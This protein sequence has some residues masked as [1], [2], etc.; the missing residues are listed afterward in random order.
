M[1]IKML[2]LLVLGMSVPAFGGPPDGA[3][4]SDAATAQVPSS[5]GACE[6]FLS[7]LHY[8]PYPLAEQLHN[9]GLENEQVQYLSGKCLV[10]GD[11][12][13]A[14]GPFLVRSGH[15]VLSADLAYTGFSTADLSYELR[16]HIDTYRKLMAGRMINDSVTNL[17]D[18]ASNSVG[19]V[20]AH[21]L[22]NNLPHGDRYRALHEMVRV[23]A[24][25]GEAYLVD[26]DDN[27][28]GENDL[29]FTLRRLEREGKIENV[30]VTSL[31]I[32]LRKDGPVRR[33]RYEFTKIK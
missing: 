26:Q 2:A 29:T 16:I 12:F 9:L 5:K 11:G 1:N 13:S 24:P 21:M 14:L 6:S 25:G 27:L 20:I 17:R 18:V 31:G 4:P 10:L 15:D 8:H 3:F 30:I 33:F 32:I 22:V 28:L 7:D 19:T 23:L